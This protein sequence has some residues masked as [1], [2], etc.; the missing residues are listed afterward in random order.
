M[1]A[2]SFTNQFQSYAAVNTTTI[3]FWET[4]LLGTATALT[5]ADFANNSNIMVSLTYFV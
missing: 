4:T 1:S 5:D 3:E 2:V